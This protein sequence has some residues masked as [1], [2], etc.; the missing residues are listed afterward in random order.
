MKLNK[1]NNI[2]DLQKQ[3]L[4][5][6][7][8]SNTKLTLGY[9]N[10]NLKNITL[11]KIEKFEKP[12]EEKKLELASVDSTNSL[13]FDE[14][15]NYKFT[16][17]AF[18]QLQNYQALLLEQEVDFEFYKTSFNSLSDKEKSVFYITTEDN[19]FYTNIIT[20]ETYEL[21]S[22]IITDLPE[23]KYDETTI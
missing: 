12:L 17:E 2:I 16:K 15:G 22:Y 20:E 18:K 21:L 8:S 13:I 23:L 11:L 9:S 5:L 14:S 1:I 10:H 4:S 19:E 3:L 7:K 6:S